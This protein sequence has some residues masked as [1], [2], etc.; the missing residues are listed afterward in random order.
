MKIQ[1]T[2]ETAIQINSLQDYHRQAKY[3]KFVCIKCGKE[4][5][6]RDVSIET[7][8]KNNSGLLCGPCLRKLGTLKNHGIETWNNSQKAKQTLLQKYG[9]TN[10]LNLRKDN[11]VVTPEMVKKRKETKL[12]L[13]GDEN[14]NNSEK[15][16]KTNQEKYGGKAPACSSKVTNKQKNTLFT[17]YGHNLPGPLASKQ[18]FLE[19][20]KLE[21]LEL[22]LIWLDEH[23]FRG[24]YDNGPIYYHFKC[25][26]CGKEFLDDF[27]S[28]KPI[29]R[30]CNP[31]LTGIS[32][33]EKDLLNYIKSI[34][35]DDILENKRTIISP[36]ELDIY[37]PKLKIAFEY[38][39]TYWHG[40]KN[41]TPFGLNEYK[42]FLEQKRI[43]CQNNG[44][45]LITIDECDYVEKSEVIHRFIKDQIL[46]RQKVFAR[47]CEIRKINTKTAKDFCEYYHVNGFRGGSE[48]F[49]LYYNND[50]LCVAIFEK[51]KKDFECTRLCYKT[52]YTIIGGWEKIQK[53]F[54]KKFLHY[55]NLKYFPGE[56]KTGCGYRILI[57]GKI[58]HRGA[59]QKKTGLYKHCKTIDPNLSDFQNCLMNNGIAIFD[60]G[61]DIR[62]YN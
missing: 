52:G 47:K 27:H 34:Y 44:I 58:L 31:K 43:L 4:E 33:Q 15:R 36:Y 5:I 30:K 45:R 51:Y 29:C 46:P 10:A 25:N 3:I 2:K 23:N 56:N 24:K 59:L 9:V 6:K 16:I 48:K 14:Y 42:K 13:Y 55:V 37:L 26:K 21:S 11:Y 7:M 61:N 41:S 18:K 38:N 50:L 17:K 22:D 49:G 62:W 53:H 1:N 19:K 60:L 39:G 20:R 40:Y 57:N 12:K 54:G 28:G 32:H 8:I 35:T